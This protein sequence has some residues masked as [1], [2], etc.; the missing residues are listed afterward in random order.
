MKQQVAARTSVVT[1]HEGSYRLTPTAPGHR[2]VDP[3]MAATA[4]AVPAPTVRSSLTV[5]LATGA[6]TAGAPIMGLAGEP[7]AEA[8]VVAEAT[9]TATPPALHVAASTPAKKSKNYDARS[10][11][12]QATMMAS[13]PSQHGLAIYFSRRNSN[14]WDH[15]VR[16]EAGSSAV[17]QMLCPLHR[18]HWWQ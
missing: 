13:L 8:T 5:T 1:V 10:P 14:L 15:Q 11:P 12:R 6:V 2:P 9:R 16:R 4:P 7:G 18:K 17:S 3:L